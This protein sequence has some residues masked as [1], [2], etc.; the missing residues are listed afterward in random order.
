[1]ATSTRSRPWFPQLLSPRDL[2][3]R[4][5]PVSPTRAV[6]Y[7]SE[8]VWND[9]DDGGATGGGIS[10]TFG[11]PF[12]QRLLPPATQRMLGGHRGTPDI[13]WN[14]DELTPVL[15]YLSFLGP[16]NAGYYV[17]AARVRARR[18]GRVSSPT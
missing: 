2:G 1:M 11:E 5:E 10:Q 4:H 7:Q 14:A 16:D 12:Y 9:G 8:T 18:S 6:D 17:S 15:I 13:S 3:R